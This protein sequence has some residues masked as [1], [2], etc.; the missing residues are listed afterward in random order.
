MEKL[1][2]WT[3]VVIDFLTWTFDKSCQLYNFANL[4]HVQ[5]IGVQRAT[6][7]D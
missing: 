5:C 7:C 1:S 2:V 3:I 6:Y 4:A